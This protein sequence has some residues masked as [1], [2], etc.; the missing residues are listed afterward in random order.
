MEKEELERL[1]SIVRCHNA[2]LR[3]SG[4]WPEKK[5]D[6]R[7]MNKILDKLWRINHKNGC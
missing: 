1:A 4:D 5:L 2:V 7:I 6:E 3:G